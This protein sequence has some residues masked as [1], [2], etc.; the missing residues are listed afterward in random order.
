MLELYQLVNDPRLIVAW[1]VGLATSC[2]IVA[3]RT[4]IAN[5]TELVDDASRKPHATHKGRVPIIGGITWICG[6]CAFFIAYL[7]A[8]L[9]LNLNETAELEIAK[10]AIYILYIGIFF[11]IGLID[12]V[13]NLSPRFRLV[14]STGTVLILAVAAEPRLALNGVADNFT[15]FSVNFGYLTTLI[16]VI[17]VVGIVNA[18]NMSDGRNGIVAGIAVI[19][20]LALICKNDNSLAVAI[21][22][23]IAA[24]SVFSFISKL[25]KQY[26]FGDSRSYSIGAAFSGIAVYWHSGQFSGSYLNSLE[27]FCL[28]SVPVLDMVRLMLVRLSIGRS[29]FAADHNHLHHRLDARFGWRLGLPIYL[30]LVLIPIIVAFQPF[31]VAGLLGVVAAGVSYVYA[32]RITQRPDDLVSENGTAE[33]GGGKLTQL[34]SEN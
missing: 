29:P 21:L 27:M 2:L 26:F 34:P 33:T 23:S 3:N 4:K 13:R 5:A 25:K 15:L 10:F 19:W 16:T 9:F 28:F 12:D 17:A 1:A 8:I 24:N 32:I 31:K 20:S 14:V 11:I 7:F 22:L 18:L 30:G 6:T